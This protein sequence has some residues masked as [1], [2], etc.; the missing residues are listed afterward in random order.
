MKAIIDYKFNG[1]VAGGISVFEDGR[2]IAVT[3]TTSKT[4]KSLKS[5]EKHMIALDY[6]KA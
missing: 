4:Y 2:Y 1:K 3:R 6:V 5:A